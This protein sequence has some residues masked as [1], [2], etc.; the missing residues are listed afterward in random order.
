MSDNEKEIRRLK[1]LLDRLMMQADI[2]NQEAKEGSM[3]FELY[4]RGKSELENS[5][6]KEL[7]ELVHELKAEEATLINNQGKNAQIQ[8]LLSKLDKR[9][10]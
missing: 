2:A 3:K 8:Y 1:I 9:N 6:Q 7:D 4:Y 5:S 10:N